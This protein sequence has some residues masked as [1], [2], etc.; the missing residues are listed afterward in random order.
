MCFFFIQEPTVTKTYLLKCE[1]F[2]PS[3][4]ADRLTRLSQGLPGGRAIPAGTEHLHRCSHHKH[5]NS[6]NSWESLTGAP[7]AP[8]SPFSP[9]I[10]YPG[11]P[12][13]RTHWHSGPTSSIFMSPRQ[14]GQFGTSSPLDQASHAGPG[15]IRRT[16][17][18]LL[19][20][21]RGA[22]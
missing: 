12:C 10:P 20:T 16:H 2:L 19:T 17:C 11:S 9:F 22:S 18:Q 3:I 6:S 8:P 5:Q 15:K 13:R 7:G 14:S 1:P 4:L 21:H